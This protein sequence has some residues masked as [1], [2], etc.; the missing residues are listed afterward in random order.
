MAQYNPIPPSI[1][2]V[3][4]GDLRKPKSLFRSG[5][6]TGDFSYK[7]IMAS[8]A[9]PACHLVEASPSQ[10]IHS[11]PGALPHRHTRPIERTR[12]VQQ[13]SPLPFTESVCHEA[14]SHAPLADSS[15]RGT[16]P[17][18]L[19]QVTRR[20]WVSRVGFTVTKGS[21]PHVLRA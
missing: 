12:A 6:H 15:S 3:S 1:P 8:L 11:C 20:S 19:N 16:R 13:V 7:V 4:A 10:P 5:Y 9:L 18:N 17:H 21:Q 14:T 2:F